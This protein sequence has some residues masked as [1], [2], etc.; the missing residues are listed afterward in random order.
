MKWYVMVPLTLVLGVAFWIVLGAFRD[1]PGTSIIRLE[2]GGIA[3]LGAWLC[4]V[5]TGMA[6]QAWRRY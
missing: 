6:L 1:L 4:A 3:G 5:W 2:P